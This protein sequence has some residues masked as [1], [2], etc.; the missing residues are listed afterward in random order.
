MIPQSIINNNILDDLSIYFISS[1]DSIQPTR[2]IHHHAQNKHHHNRSS[3]LPF[4][5]INLT[6]PGGASGIGQALA[7]HFASS[8]SSSTAETPNT[9]NNTT[10]TTHI[11]ILDI[12]PTTGEET[13]DSLRAQYPTANLS[14]HH[15]DVTS[16]DSQAAAFYE[17][18]KAQGRIDFVFANAGVTEKG[19]LLPSPGETVPTKPDLRTVEA[20]FLGVLF[21][22]FSFFSLL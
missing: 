13:L 18:Y 2:P 14:F 16:W 3:S 11:S 21:S 12:N 4:L 5:D 17:V 8:S 19:S 1:P 22:E 9:T 7:T 10:S 15:C 20:N 6:K